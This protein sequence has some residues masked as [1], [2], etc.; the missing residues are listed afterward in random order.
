MN[1]SRLRIHAAAAIFALSACGQAPSR[2][3]APAAQ[4]SASA[5]AASS[6]APASSAAQAPA[7]PIC[8]QP[9]APKAAAYPARFPQLGAAELRA[10]ADDIARA[11]GGFVEKVDLDPYGFLIRMQTRPVGDNDRSR[12]IDPAELGP[13]LPV[14]ACAGSALGA[15]EVRPVVV[16]SQTGRGWLEATEV[17]AGSTIGRIDVDAASNPAGG[18]LWTVRVTGHFWPGVTV[19]DAVKVHAADFEAKLVGA[20][21][22]SVTV[23]GP[24]PCAKGSPCPVPPPLKK[25]VKVTRDM[26]Q[27]H[28][29]VLLVRKAND[30][31]LEVR[32][33][34]RIDLAG[35]STFTPKGGAPRVPILVD[36][37]TGD[38]LAAWRWCHLADGSCHDFSECGNDSC[39]P[40]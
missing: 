30:G 32:R 38:D 25:T 10:R 12:L 2:P 17:V 1:E 6:S 31:P 37:V 26:I 27:S 11:S 5:P 33:V 23:L 8:A 39:N 4:P 34:L 13:W 19:P 3:S 40:M 21:Y 15:S 14:L 36:S 35:A 29:A 22:D 24:P 7:P 9:P 28:E 16:S 18:T 20:T